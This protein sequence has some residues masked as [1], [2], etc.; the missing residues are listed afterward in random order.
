MNVEKV[1]STTAVEPA[2]ILA[3]EPAPDLGDQVS[4]LDMERE[5]WTVHQDDVRQK[6]LAYDGPVFVDLDE[7][8]Y[9]RNSTEVFLSL[10]MP[11]LLAAFL[12]RMLDMARPWRFAGGQSCRDNWRVLMILMVFP[13]TYVRWQ[14]YCRE[15]V[16]QEVNGE[17]R[18]ALS[19][20]SHPVIIAS[21]GYSLLIRP[22]LP[23]LGLPNAALVC[24]RLL[25]LR[26][27][28]DG[29]LALVKDCYGDSFI[30]GSFVITD[31][32]T[33]ADLMRASRD[34]CLTTWN[35]A[36][37]ERAFDGRIYLPGD[38]LSRVKRPG[39]GALRSLV[40]YDL[41]P[42]LLIG[43]SIT[44]G[45]YQFVGL[46]AL[47]FSMWAVY[48]IG[49][50]DNDQC[51]RQYEIDP[52]LTSEAQAFT[53]QQFEF[54]AWCTALLLGGIGVLLI[55]PDTFILALLVW[56][57]VLLA[58]HGTYWIYNRVDK[59]S[60][61]WLYAVLQMFRFGSI[62]FMV[63]AGPVAVA[64]ATAQ[65][66]ARWIDYIIYRYQRSMGILTWPKTANQAV[67]MTIFIMLVTPLF[68]TQNWQEFGSTAS[69]CF[70]I[71]AYGLWKYEWKSHTASFY[72]LDRPSLNELM[73]KP[74][75]PTES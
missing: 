16:P 59:T 62:F 54:K 58:L 8:L 36:R 70:F 45:I 35:E 60:R 37:F 30:A 4:T 29:K 25:N 19:S 73:K 38:Y 32:Y 33:D 18:Q 6:I 7:T 11:G 10:A 24:C 61:I 51:A 47:F 41:L 39:K 31:S 65:M 42:W 5:K 43:L 12:L 15:T 2:N 72:R 49:Y 48:E 52:V 22:M 68:I 53:V 64:A 67:R 44:P 75:P 3:P 27:R 56:T 66:I 17:L 34:A 69:L 71:F 14:Q 26:H 1:L 63:A 20:R 40:L 74:A 13:W 28:R 55:R 21:N 50:Y 57:G 46:I 23:F 9:L